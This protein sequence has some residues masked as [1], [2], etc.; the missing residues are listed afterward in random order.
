MHRRTFLISTAIIG[1]AGCLGACSR[2]L[3]TGPTPSIAPAPT[4]G[5][6]SRVLPPAD[7][8]VPSS[9]SEF[10]LWPEVDIQTTVTAL[11]KQHLCGTA[12]IPELDGRVSNGLCPV[13]VDLSGPSTWAII[14][15]GKENWSI[16]PVRMSPSPSPSSSS[17]PAT[18]AGPYDPGPT[19]AIG[20]A[21]L[22]DSY[23][24]ITAGIHST[25]NL[26]SEPPKGPASI[27]VIKVSLS[28]HTIVASICVAK[29]YVVNDKFLYRV[30]LTLDVEHGTLLIVGDTRG[31]SQKA[32]SFGFRI[33]AADLSIQFDASTVLADGFQVEESLGEA[34]LVKDKAVIVYLVTGVLEDRGSKVIKSVKDGWVY[35]KESDNSSR[36]LEAYKRDAFRAQ[37]IA[38]GENI[39]LADHPQQFHGLA[40]QIPIYTNQHEVILYGE[41]EDSIF[42]VRQPGSATPILSWNSGERAIP[43]TACVFGDI[44]YLAP[45]KHASN[46]D[47]ALQLVS[48]SAGQD[49]NE[50]PISAWGDSIAVSSWGIVL[51]DAF[52]PADAWFG[53]PSGTSEPTPTAVNS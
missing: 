38:T 23:A 10:P 14:P 52:Y 16:M 1:V 3:K 47:G 42:S 29:N 18:A 50:I 4:L 35:Y 44:A 33:S 9:F 26:T 51:H 25:K 22:D 40:T 39:L 46:R 30:T 41:Y 32:D 27:H 6:E 43:S 36:E 8:A 7:G 11:H 21:V 34:L 15:D 13:V 20:P 17:S 24:Y 48:L 31:V 37:N 49:V 19:I 12:E 45:S 2:N 53:Y 5:P 28:D